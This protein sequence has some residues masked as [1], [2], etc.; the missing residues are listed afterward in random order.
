V[1]FAVEDDEPADPRDVGLFCTATVVTRTNGG[2]D[3]VEKARL[4]RSIG[5]GL[6]N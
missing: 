3:A 1:A 6:S 4:W 2:P 5:V